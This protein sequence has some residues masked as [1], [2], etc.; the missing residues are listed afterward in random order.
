[1]PA[2]LGDKNASSSMCW[3]AEAG[4]RLNHWM[5]AL[6]GQRDAMLAL[7]GLPAEAPADE[8]SLERRARSLA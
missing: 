5:D 6:E 1:M 4:R 8:R 7:D 2:Y 3:P